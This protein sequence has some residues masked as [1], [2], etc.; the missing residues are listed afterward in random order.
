MYIGWLNCFENLS[1]EKNIM[2][3]II[4]TSKKYTFDVIDKMK[5]RPNIVDSFKKFI[6]CNS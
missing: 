4:K 5:K 2:K 3:N 6:D 1:I